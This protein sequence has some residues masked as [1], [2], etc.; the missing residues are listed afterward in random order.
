MTTSFSSGVSER[1]TKWKKP[2]CVMCAGDHK[3]L[4]CDDFHKMKPAERLQLVNSHDLC[5]ICL[6]GNH[7]TNKCRKGYCCMVPGCSQRHS[8]FIHV[9]HVLLV[10]NRPFRASCCKCKYFYNCMLTH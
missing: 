1:S 3:V 7:K 6:M 5:K 4:Y 8:K 2:L 10:A 9:S